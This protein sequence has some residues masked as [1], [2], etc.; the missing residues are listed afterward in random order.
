MYSV[1]DV[2]DMGAA[3]ELILCYVKDIL[4]WDDIEQYT[5]PWVEDFDE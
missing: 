5:L 1:S 4:R 2:L 3:H